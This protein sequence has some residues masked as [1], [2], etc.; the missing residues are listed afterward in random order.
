M[1]AIFASRDVKGQHM[2]ETD[3]REIFTGYDE[4]REGGAAGNLLVLNYI[5][6]Y[7]TSLYIVSGLKRLSVCRRIYII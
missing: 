4:K 1:S 7:C 3:G 5:K 2:R 6:I